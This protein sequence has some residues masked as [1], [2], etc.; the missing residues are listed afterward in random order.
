[1]ETIKKFVTVAE[2]ARMLGLSRSRFYQLV[3]TTFPFPIYDVKTRRP[4]FNEELQQACL[5]VR[6]RNCGVDGKPVFFYCR[7]G[8]S[9]S[10]KKKP[11]AAKPNQ[12]ADLIDGLQALGLTTT[13]EQVAV[14]MRFLYPA[15]VGAAT[16]NDVLRTVFLHLKRQNRGDNVG[17]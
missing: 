6:R 11:K 13:A 3:G 5:D 2:M 4:Y 16:E 1:M 8:G 12:Y 17:R 7:G 10:A 14:S 15:G 9:S